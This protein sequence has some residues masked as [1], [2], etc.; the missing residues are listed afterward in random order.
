MLFRCISEA[1]LPAVYEILPEDNGTT[2][3]FNIKAEKFPHVLAFLR[4]SRTLLPTEQNLGIGPFIPPHKTL[5]WGF[6]PALITEEQS[7]PGW[8]GIL[9]ELPQLFDNCSA[10]GREAGW[11]C[12][13]A[14]MAS[15]SHLLKSC[16]CIDELVNHSTNSPT[17]QLEVMTGVYRDSSDLRCDIGAGLSLRLAN[18][19]ATN[20]ND[21]LRSKVTEH[22]TQAYLRLTGKS[23]VDRYEMSEIGLHAMNSPHCTT[24]RTCGDRC[25][26]YPG[27]AFTHTRGY[28]LYAHNVDTPIQ[29]LVLLM[30]LASLL[31]QFKRGA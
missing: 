14:T 7:T 12:A 27:N 23:S 21:Y 8:R 4:N 9:C 16:S 22:M 15:I 28:E 3:R 20:N 2:L 25:S 18:W 6:N 10:D 17:Q 30:G 31:Q 1:H 24:F 13:I 11:R 5:P 29:V 26:L 19:F